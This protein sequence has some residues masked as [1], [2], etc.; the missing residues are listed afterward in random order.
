MHWFAL[1]RSMATNPSTLLAILSNI[2]N[3]IYSDF[4]IKCHPST[5]KVHRCIICPQSPFFEKALCG[6]F[7]EAKTRV[8]T[9]HDDPTIISKMIDY[10]YRGDYDDT[11]DKKHP[12]TN[13][14]HEP[15]TTKAHVSI[16]MYNVADKYAVE[17]LMALA[18]EKLENRLTLVRDNEEFFRIIEKVY[19][20]DSPQNSKLRD[21]VARFAVE[22]L[23][24]LNGVSEFHETRKEC[25][26]FS[27][28]F[29][30][31]LIDKIA[32]VEGKLRDFPIW[33][34]LKYS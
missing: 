6:K 32:H 26:L 17:P 7:Q 30:T 33:I 34:R 16:A 20:P 27:Y 1:L 13:P 25:P 15:P 23:D 4:E 18:K 11:P 8:V 2:R 3:G 5:F 10:F 31:L 9:I 29:S 19:G 24:T 22:H 28:D 21:T 12:A 14:E